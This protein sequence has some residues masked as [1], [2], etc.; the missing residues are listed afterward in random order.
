[1]LN[2]LA[3]ITSLILSP[4]LVP[5]AS[6]FIVV[7]TYAE[8]S[9]Q[10]AL[11]TAISVAFS[12]G[13]PFVLI[14]VMVRLGMLSGMHIA[15]R[16][17]RPGILLFGLGCA[18]CGTGILHQIGA[19]KAIVWLGITYAINGVVFLVLTQMWKISFHTGVTAGCVTALTLMV[20][21]NF[22]WFFLLLLPIAWARIYRKRH[23]FIQAI[24]GGGLA[25]IVTK[26]VLWQ[27]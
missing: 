17:Q 24:A 19:P 27:F 25:V 15:I 10:F 6:T 9:E 22:A 26:L 21:S 13:L 20:N 23:T 11:W 16:E 7:R 18:L 14:L 3:A 1:M 8:N 4:F 5:I 12:T 2:R